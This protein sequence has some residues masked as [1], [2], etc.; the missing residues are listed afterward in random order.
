MYK[1]GIDQLMVMSPHSSRQQYLTDHATPHVCIDFDRAGGLW[2]L[3]RLHQEIKKYQPHIIVAWL[4]RSPRLLP[5]HS[6]AIKVGRVGG[7]YKGKNYSN[8]DYVVANSIPLQDFMQE[9]GYKDALCISNF[10][11]E[12]PRRANCSPRRRPLLFF[13][14]RLHPQKGLD[15]L[16]HALR[17]ID[18]DAQIVGAGPLEAQ[19]RQRALLSGVA[20]RIDFLGWQKN[21][22][23]YLSQADV[24]VFPSR[25]EGTS[26]SLLEAM[27]CGKPIITTNAA[28]VSWFLTHEK[29]ALI[30][31]ADNAEQLARATNRLI[32]EPELA[33]RLGENARKLYLESFT[34]D[35]ICN[36]WLAFFENILEIRES[37]SACAGSERVTKFQLSRILL[38][39]SPNTETGSSSLGP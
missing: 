14:G 10:I 23:S 34:E 24:Y 18:A 33:R 5:R 7:Y 30:V 6:N 16:I 21:A 2:G 12:G 37:S 8:C 19:L 13:H 32:R 15:I 22:W 27:A 9:Q 36:Q 17:H 3:W 35:A 29:N 39:R 11:E 20:H 31:D 4:K 26:N 38:G 28:S 1:R 25:Y